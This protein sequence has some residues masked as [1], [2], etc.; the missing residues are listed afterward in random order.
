MA[1]CLLAASVAGAQTQLPAGF[2]EEQL[3]RPGEIAPP[4]SMAFAPDG[5][6]LICEQAGRVRLLKNG[7][8]SPTPFLSVDTI[9]FQE[10]GLTG[11]T[12][13]P[14]FADNG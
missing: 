5:R 1:A 9:A 4:T 2:S 10:R 8:L 7:M 6:L 13:D 12:L 3:L 11:I 14:N